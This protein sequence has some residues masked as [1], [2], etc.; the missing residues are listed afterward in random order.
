MDELLHAAVINCC[1]K[2]EKKNVSIDYEY[3]NEVC[4]IIGHLKLLQEKN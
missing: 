1:K 4:R 3:Y 2:I